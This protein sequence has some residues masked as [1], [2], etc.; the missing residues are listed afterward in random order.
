[1][2]LV[3]LVVVWILGLSACLP[4]TNRYELV[5]SAATPPSIALAT[6]TRIPVMPTT[7]VVPP[8]VVVPT[9]TTILAGGSVTSAEEVSVVSVTPEVVWVI[10]P[11]PEPTVTGAVIVRL[12]PRTATPLPPPPSPTPTTPPPPPLP[13]AT[14]ERPTPTAPPRTPPR[15][16]TGPILHLRADLPPMTL[17]QWER[18]Q[19]DNGRCM[20]WSRNQYFSPEFMDANLPRLQL[21]SAKWVV[22]VYGDE[23]VLHMAAP[24][25]AEAGIIPI[26]RRML[27]PH[28]QYH[29]WARDV[30]LVKSYGLPPYFQVYNEPSL[31]QEWVDG[32]EGEKDQQLFLNNLMQASREVYNAGGYVGWQFVS[33]PWLDRAI[34]EAQM[35]NATRLFERFFFVPHS[36]GDN[37]PPAWTEDGRGVLGWRNFADQLHRRLG[38]VPPL[39][40]GEGGWRINSHDEPRFPPMDETT[41]A[42]YHVELFD[43]FRTG[44]LSNGEPLPDYLFAYCPW[45]IAEKGDDNAW[46]DS[47]AGDR[48]ITAEAIAAMP[49]FVRRLP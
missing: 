15:A 42:R 20:H 3:L 14:A 46:W 45:L 48:L 43:W 27:R 35:R 10:T 41:H 23:N 4:A 8:T 29:E 49:P 2:R 18:P 28:E 7:P 11:L 32:W 24:R 22:V 21:L 16:A 36:Y 17:T 30:E 40:V 12:P 47:F 38:F 37:I 34:D 6:L 31:G 9:P 25:F 26:W 44:I 13:T 39:I 19:G 5:D 33:Q 1:M